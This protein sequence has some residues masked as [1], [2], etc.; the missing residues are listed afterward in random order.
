MDERARP[1]IGNLKRRFDPDRFHNITGKPLSGNLTI[2]KIA[3]LQ[4]HQPGLI[5]KTAK[6]LDNHAFLVYF[7]PGEYRTSSG[8]A[9]PTG[10]FDL[11]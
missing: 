8:S 5:R 3:W 1:L 2:S 10:L 7:L 6:F 11:E 4:E 9:G